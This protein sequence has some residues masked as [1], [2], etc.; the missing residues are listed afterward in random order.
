ML[1]VQKMWLKSNARKHVLQIVPI[2]QTDLEN[3]MLVQEGKKRA[4]G[5]ATMWVVRRIGARQQLLRF[6]PSPVEHAVVKTIKII[7]S[8]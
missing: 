1:C 6:A 2:V 5:S 3:S 4:N 8:L 7:E